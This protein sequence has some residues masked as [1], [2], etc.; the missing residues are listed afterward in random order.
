M[1]YNRDKASRP[2]CLPC[3]CAHLA[4]RPVSAA[5][6]SEPV[7]ALPALYTVDFVHA[8]CIVALHSRQHVSLDSAVGAA[9]KKK[10][11]EKPTNL[12]VVVAPGPAYAPLCF[13]NNVQSDGSVRS[14][15]V[16]AVTVRVPAGG[17]TAEM[18][19]V[20]LLSVSVI[21]RVS[22]DFSLFLL[23]S[24]VAPDFS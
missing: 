18:R 2:R 17:E 3:V 6:C 13:L 22:R 7:L 12:Q 8:A 15:E 19:G 14:G 4:R 24:L 5:A 21:S 1:C 10:Q 23:M 11:L 20:G 9:N 16:A